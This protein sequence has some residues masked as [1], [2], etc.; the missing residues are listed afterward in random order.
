ME[1]TTA[2]YEGEERMKR[3]C[4]IV[5]DEE[6]MRQM[7]AEILAG[8]EWKVR[9]A[10]SAEEAMKVLDET[11]IDLIFLD[12]KLFG[13]NGIELCRLIRQKNPVPVI[14]AVTGWA[15]LFELSECREAGFD[16]FFT[17]PVDIDLLAK[18]AREAYEK[19][20][21]WEHYR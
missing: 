17:K 21:R 1:M 12:L 3:F 5:D 18:A 19:L 6:S 2:D 4:L 16:D 11:K 13:L 9:T 14:Y 10:A 8:P 7:L 20:Q 15:G